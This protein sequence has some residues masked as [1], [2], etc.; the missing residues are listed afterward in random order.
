MVAKRDALDQL[1][2]NGFDVNY[3]DGLLMFYGIDFKAATK[4]CKTI[5]YNSSYGCRERKDKVN[6]QSGVDRKIN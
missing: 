4:A 6:E 2:K 5:G 3:Q 1:K